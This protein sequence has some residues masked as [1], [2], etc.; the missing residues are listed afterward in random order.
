MLGFGRA[1]FRGLRLVLW[2]F[3]SCVWDVL[4]YRILKKT[5]FEFFGIVV[6]VVL[7]CVQ[8][9]WWF[10]KPSDKYWAISPKGKHKLSKTTL[11][12]FRKCLF[13]LW[14][15]CCFGCNWKT[16][17]GTSSD[18]CTWNNTCFLFKR[19]V[20]F[21]L[22]WLSKAAFDDGFYV[23][24]L[25]LTVQST[26]FKK[27]SSSFFGNVVFVVLDCVPFFWMFLYNFLKNVGQCHQNQ[28]TFLLKWHW[29]RPKVFTLSCA[30]LI[31]LVVNKKCVVR[32][33]RD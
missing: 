9:F 6:F 2:L 8:L 29:G 12:T 15:A 18:L 28:L 27:N 33:S 19:R 20:T 30:W 4:R 14:W 1:S 31:S 7:Y 24:Y 32:R 23:V 10:Y 25:R 16:A 11:S 17:S 13:E 22:R 5:A 3:T 26:N 21:E